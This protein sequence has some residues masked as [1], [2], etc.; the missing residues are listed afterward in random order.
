M[1][2]FLFAIISL[3]A[4]GAS[5]KVQWLQT[6]CDFG[7]FDESVGPV[8]TEFR[9][10]NTSAEP[11]AIVSARASCG[12][13]SPVYAKEPVAPGDTASIKVTYDPAGRPGRFT[14]YV[15][16]TLSDGEPMTKLYVKGAVVGSEQSVSQRFPAGCGDNF[17][18]AKGA[19]MIGDVVKGQLRTVFLD[20]YN[21]STDTIA[22]VVEGL[23]P[24]MEV[25]VTPEKVPP[26]EQMTFIFYM[27]SAKCPLY[28]IVTDTVA[29]RPDRNAPVACE[30]P[31]IAMVN[32]DFSKLSPKQL[33]KAPRLWLEN[34]K[35][36]FGVLGSAHV[37]MPV[38]IKNIG[39]SPLKI[40]RLYTAD[41]G[42]TVTCDS[43]TV[44]P[45][46]TAVVTVSV[47]PAAL[48]GALLNARISLITNDPDSPQS[49]IRAVGSFK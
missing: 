14:K 27:H 7:A 9:F 28:G 24:Y 31:A 44:K 29:I 15:G 13:T 41:A 12:C 35:A 33:E 4:L 49:T 18:L 39:K 32:E 20:G 8:S 47:D 11:V 45:G 25:N 43:E 37:S 22:P 42:V 38:T 36:D 21:R 5:A 23:P 40:R 30:I 17:R 10:V 16:V 1:K 26:G 2:A 19:V 3:M 6:T 48:P 34:P 46:K